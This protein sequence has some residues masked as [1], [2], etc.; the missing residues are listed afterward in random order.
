MPRLR[1]QIGELFAVAPKLAVHLLR[2][3]AAANDLNTLASCYMQLPAADPEDAAARSRLEGQRVYLFRLAYGH[4]HEAVRVLKEMGADC[5][6][7]LNEVRPE[8][9][10]KYNNIAT[11][12]APLEGGLSRLRAHATFHYD[13]SE[14]EGVLRDWG[15][16]AEGE[17]VIGKSRGEIR[18]AVADEAFSTAI[19]RAFNLPPLDT[20]EGKRAAGDL[21]DRLLPLQFDLM[22]YV[23]GLLEAVRRIHPGVIK[24]VEA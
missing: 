17:V 8:F 6:H 22:D 23:L 4:L 18:Y 9:R 7:V 13:Y 24:L 14:V 21:L 16:D 12:I 1:L 15:A 3:M 5:P 10:E 20:P 11:T 2:L 19:R